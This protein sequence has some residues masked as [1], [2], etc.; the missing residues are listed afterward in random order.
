MTPTPRYHFRAWGCMVRHMRYSFLR[1][2]L[3]IH[4]HFGFFRCTRVPHVFTHSSKTFVK[5]VDTVCL[6]SLPLLTIT[7]GGNYSMRNGGGGMKQ[8]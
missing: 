1:F 8:V 2:K 6:Y 3:G 7:R 5:H 4:R